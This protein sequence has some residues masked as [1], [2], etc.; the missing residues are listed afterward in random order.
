MARPRTAPL[1]TEK[2]EPDN[3]LTKKQITIFVPLQEWLTIRREA[4]R[5]NIPITELC[6][7]LIRPEL[8]K[9]CHSDKAA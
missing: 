7:K 4:A 8:D 6:R 9:L 2:T 3:L 5:L 1:G